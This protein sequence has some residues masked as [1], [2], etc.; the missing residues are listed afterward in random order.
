MSSLQSLFLSSLFFASHKRLSFLDLISSRSVASEQDVEDLVAFIES[1]G[2][3]GAVGGEKGKPHKLKTKTSTTR[4]ESRGDEEAV[5]EGDQGV[6]VKPVV[7]KEEPKQSKTK[8]RPRRRRKK[9]RKD[10]DTSSEATGGLPEGQPSSPVADEEESEERSVLGGTSGSSASKG[11]GREG[12]G[13][14][15]ASQEDQKGVIATPSTARQ[16]GV[17]EEGEK[18][19]STVAAVA[20]AGGVKDIAE[21]L[22]SGELALDEVEALFD[23][24]NFEDPDEEMVSVFSFVMS[25][26]LRCIDPHSDVSFLGSQD[27]EV[28]RF[29]LR[30]NAQ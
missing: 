23:E 29:R 1:G 30:L 19:N 14:P 13:I 20:A 27:E 9:K 6:E 7:E 11:D 22:R 15:V 16:A 4:G 3:A 17:E 26:G 10:T 8:S 18:V 24:T 28:E 5:G 25:R 12:G 21:K 2:S